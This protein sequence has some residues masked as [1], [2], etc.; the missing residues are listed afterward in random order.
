MNSSTEKGYPLTYGE[1][2]SAAV[3]LGVAPSLGH[4]ADERVNEALVKSLKQLKAE[5]LSD[6]KYHLTRTGLQIEP[7]PAMYGTAHPAPTTKE[8]AVM[9]KKAVKKVVKT[10]TAKEARGFKPEAKITAKGEMPY[11]ED[12][13]YGRAAALAAKSGTVEKYR[14]SFEKLKDMGTCTAGEVLRAASACGYLKIA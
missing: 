2:C 8:K 1:L 13:R 7:A 3:M 14:A 11:K 10:K 4:T 6:G 12:S 5:R 9:A